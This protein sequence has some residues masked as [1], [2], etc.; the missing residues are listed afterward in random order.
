MV[1]KELRTF[2][3][4]VLDEP[5]IITHTESPSS[6]GLDVEWTEYNAAVQLQASEVTGYIVFYKSNQ[7]TRYFFCSP[8]FR[9]LSV[10][11]RINDFG[12]TFYFCFDY[13]NS[14]NST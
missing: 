12:N 10:L 4:V 14:S 3:F 6:T 5:L 2:A 8:A 13:R 1:V 7:E 9:L 11:S